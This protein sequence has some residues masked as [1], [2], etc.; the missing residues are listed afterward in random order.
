M[1][2]KIKYTVSWTYVI[3][4]INGEKV[5][6]TFYEN[7]LQMTNQEEFRMEKVIQK[8]PIS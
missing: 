7:E 5:L 8:N 1:I 4:D 2:S 6:G 3:S